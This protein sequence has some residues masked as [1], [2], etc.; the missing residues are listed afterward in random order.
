MFEGNVLDLSLNAEKVLKEYVKEKGNILLAVSSLYRDIIE[1]ASEKDSRLDD[2]VCS[3]Y[4]VISNKYK[5]PFALPS[6]FFT[7]PI[8]IPYLKKSLE[9]AYSS[10]P[11]IYNLYD[12]TLNRAAFL[13][14]EY[15]YSYLIKK[16]EDNWTYFICS[17]FLQDDINILFY[18][19]NSLSIL[20]EQ[21]S[22]NLLLPGESHYSFSSFKQYVDRHIKTKTILNIEI[23][24]RIYSPKYETLY[25][26]DDSSIAR[27]TRKAFKK[28]NVVITQIGGKDEQRNK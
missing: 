1:G 27:E 19:S 10:F 11:L 26:T 23:L 14:N 4:E 16:Y 21:F 7:I 5:D 9:V 3:L 25:Q 20:K 6:Y 12:I 28:S 13:D 15:A 22:H 8:E 24:K 17:F 2:W 18:P